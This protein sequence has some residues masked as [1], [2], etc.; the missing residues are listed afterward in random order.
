MDSRIRTFTA[1]GPT[2]WLLTFLGAREQGVRPHSGLAAGPAEWLL[3]F[4]D[5]ERAERAARQRPEAV[6]AR[7]GRTAEHPFGRMN[8]RSA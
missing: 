2:G 1:A 5:A 3:V 6:P 7:A 8:A 4:L